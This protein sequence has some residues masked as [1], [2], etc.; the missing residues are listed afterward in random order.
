VRIAFDAGEAG[1]A[2]T[3]PDSLSLLAARVLLLARLLRLPLAPL[4]SDASP[5]SEDM[6]LQCCCCCR[7]EEKPGSKNLDVALSRDRT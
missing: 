5:S 4:C 2:I 7:Q 3:A 6:M 1:A